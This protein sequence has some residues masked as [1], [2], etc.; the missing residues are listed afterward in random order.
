MSRWISSWIVWGCLIAGAGCVTGP[1]D[2]AAHQPSSPLAF[3]GYASKPGE[4]I[5]VHAMDYCSRSLQRIATFT[6]GTTPT[7]FN[8]DTLYAWSG[9][10]VFTAL[11]AWSCYW[12]P[13]VAPR[14]AE[15]RVQELSTGNMLTSFEAGGLNCV[16]DKLSAGTG[17]LAAGEH[18]ASVNSPSINLY[19]NDVR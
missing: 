17:W 19:W 8:G 1:T 6:A 3:S 5:V 4:T 11:P 10:L 18:C 14:H 2:G 9:S 16:I 7:T 15:L 13:G 12:D